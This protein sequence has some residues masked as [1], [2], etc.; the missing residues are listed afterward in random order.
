MEY[1]VSECNEPLDNNITTFHSIKLR[2]SSI[3]HHSFFSVR[4]LNEDTSKVA[5]RVLVYNDVISYFS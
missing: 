5:I 2:V 1:S 3:D 4:D